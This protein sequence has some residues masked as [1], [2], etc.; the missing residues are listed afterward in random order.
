MY[1]ILNLMTTHFQ[2]L[3]MYKQSKGNWPLQ[4]IGPNRNELENVCMLCKHIEHY[5]MQYII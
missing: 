4:N 3:A 1:T 2:Y 5:I